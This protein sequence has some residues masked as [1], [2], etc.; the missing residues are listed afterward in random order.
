MPS[1]LIFIAFAFTLAVGAGIYALSSPKETASDAQM[2]QKAP[3][4]GENKK[5][6]D[7]TAEGA[8][9]EGTEH[10]HNEES[11]GH[12]ETT[13]ITPQ[14]EKDAGIKLEE[15]G[16]ASLRETI[17]LTGR[18]M[19]NPNTTAHVKARFPGVVRE[20]M[21]GPGESVAKDE[22]L[23]RVE[24]NES[25]QIYPVKSPIN[26]VVLSRSTNV[27]D[28]AGDT[29]IFTI[30]NTSDLWAEFHVFPRDIDQIQT[31]QKV[32][33]TSFEGGHKGE[34]IITT[35]L[36]V[37][38]SSSQTVIARVTLP[39]PE[40]L[41]RAGMTVRGDVVIAE[42]QV[43]VAVRNTAIQRLEGET[44]VFVKEGDRFEARPI[45]IGI[46]DGDWT[47]VLEGL[48]AGEAYVSEKSFRIK[49]HI[50][51]AGAEHEH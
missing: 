49:A 4:D 47:E 27:G 38:E 45:R 20:V 1:K 17:R 3:V 44:V 50:G 18:V 23:A 8:K 2:T 10:A 35:L 24:S 21:K 28:V 19:L 42:R 14:A 11:E 34:A 31:G 51:K 15:A 41:W 12:G 37:A 5:L 22:V 16:T 48:G 6:S 32:L 30:T 46:S 7:H 9:S 40:G 26:G 33:I 36:P 13:T 29:P 25:L 39:N 43:S